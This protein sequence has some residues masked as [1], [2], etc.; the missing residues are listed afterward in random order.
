MCSTMQ[1]S[2]YTEVAKRQSWR[3]ETEKSQ[4]KEEGEREV[5]RPRVETGRTRKGPVR[6]GGGD[7]EGEKEI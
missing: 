2:E 3:G 1:Y 4:I 6:R 7:S 5:R